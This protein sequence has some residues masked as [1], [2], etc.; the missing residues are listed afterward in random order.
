MQ[1]YQVAD[2]MNLT[3]LKEF[4]PI[5]FVI[6]VAYYQIGIAVQDVIQRRLIKF[7]F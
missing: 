4:Y 1:V 6:M 3:F 7:K 2:S 5:E